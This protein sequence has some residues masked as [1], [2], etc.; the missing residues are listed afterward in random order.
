[1]LNFTNIPISVYQGV[2]DTTGTV[3]SLSDF[4]T[5]VDR[6][7]ISR[8]RSTQDPGL[9][10]R[11]KLSLPQACISGTFSPK[12]SATNLTKHSGLICVDIDRKDNMHVPN[13]DTLKDDLFCLLNN[14]AY[15]SRSVSGAGYFLIVPLAYPEEHR[16]QFTQLVNDFKEKKL[17][18]DKACGDVS[19]LRCQSFDPDAYI[20]I[21]AKPYKGLYTPP[22]RPDK[23]HFPNCYISHDADRTLKRV[24]SLCAF[25]AQYRIDLTASYHDWIR[26]G[27][28]LAS[29][30]EVGRKYFH[31]CSSQNK[32]YRQYE[33]DNLF[34]SLLRAPASSRRATIATFF[35]MCSR[36]F[37]NPA[38]YDWSN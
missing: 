16:A 35:F 38:D 9:R 33:T 7:T 17:Y 6:E 11:L 12:R 22:C 27:A 18:I 15:A 3:T 13:F 20:N 31:L 2:K 19:R 5:N 32:R 25:I 36:H 24:H 34:T 37:V 26:V 1:M 14:V 28:S 29:L 8:L 23:M 30:G 21:N 10:K 4:L